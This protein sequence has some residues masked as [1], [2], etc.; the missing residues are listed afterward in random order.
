MG[1]DE[2]ALEARKFGFVSAIIDCILC[3]CNLKEGQFVLTYARAYVIYSH[4][5]KTRQAI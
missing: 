4:G 5:R 3:R 2:K 1:N